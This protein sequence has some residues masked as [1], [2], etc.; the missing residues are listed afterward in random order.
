VVLEAVIFKS[1]GH[2]VRTFELYSKRQMSLRLGKRGIK[3]ELTLSIN[4]L[5]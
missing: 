4:P 3:L 1:V 5:L 2:L